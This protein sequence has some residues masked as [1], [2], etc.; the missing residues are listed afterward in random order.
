MK[1]KSLYIAS[2]GA[3][4][5]LKLD[6]T[7]RFNVIYGENENGKTTVMSFIKMMFYGTERSTSNILKNPRKKYL[8][9]DNSQMA[10]SIDFEHAGKNYRI[11]REFRTSN[12]T[13]R[14]TLCDLDLGTREAVG[15]DVGV[16]F[17]DLSLAAFERSVFIGQFGFPESDVQAE[18]EI[19]SKL[20]N[21]ALTGDESVS[22]EKVNSRIEKALTELKSK[23]GKKGIY[24]KNVILSEEL[25]NRIIKAEE[26]AI[27][28]KQK[29]DEIKKLETEIIAQQKQ[30]AELKETIS[31]EQDIKNAQK[32]ERLLELKENL[33]DLNQNLKLKDGSFADELF[34]RKVQ[35]CISKIDGVKNKLG[36]KKREIEILEQTM[37]GASA[38]PEEQ[39]KNSKALEDDLNII[40]KKLLDIKAEIQDL[41]SNAKEIE[42]RLSNAQNNKKK[43]GPVLLILGVLCLILGAISAV[44]ISFFAIPIILAALVLIIISI[45]I[46]SSDKKTQIALS[47][48]LADITNEILRLNIQK[49]EE[50]NNY[51]LIKT[52]LEI[53]NTTVLAS[54]A[55]GE[56][57]QQLLE[58]AKQE[59]LSF[60]AEK[61]SEE[62]ILTELF[63]R[64]KNVSSPSE[65]NDCLEQLTGLIAKQKEIKTELNYLLKYLNDISFSEAKEKLE[66]IKEGNISIS[67][68]F[69]LIKL[70]YENLLQSITDKKSQIAVLHTEIKASS[71]ASQNPEQLKKELLELKTKMESQK[72][73][74]D[75][76]G[77]ASSVLLESFAEIRSSYG[78]VLEKNA[79][80]IFEALT[81]GK[82]GKMTISKAFEISVEEKNNFGGREIAYLSSGACD[83]AYLSL[84]L[85]LL[86][87][88]CDGKEKLPV[89]LDDALAQYDDERV[90]SAL[91]FFAKQENGQT[92]MFTCHKFISETAKCM[93]ANCIELKK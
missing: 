10:G 9:W 28:L 63:S 71:N 77:V 46:K 88:I 86:S 18:G 64:Y 31:A 13:D 65:V 70:S 53:I 7:D 27:V 82:Y 40:E 36:S 58:Q 91:G 73:F 15:A 78:S 81:R 56:K 21:I 16:S 29:A 83:Q 76:L 20:S 2:F 67:E 49:S 33:D 54:A 55:A 84:R 19:N 48:Q 25:A 69:E 5:N 60:K 50:T 51:S 17:F 59:L 85:A 4:K 74:C 41:T 23:S 45:F 1:I 14:V 66:K 79:A 75:A 57:Q 42:T 8:P 6:F 37:A 38:S 72:K 24:D 89:F 90:K 26:A 43:T 62:N 68:N 39:I 11:E 87:L 12:S 3:I 47:K 22:F 61:E 35:F 80:E 92:I 34:L 44:F 52:K 93:G 32:I 30:A